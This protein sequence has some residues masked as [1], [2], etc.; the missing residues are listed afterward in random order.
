LIFWFF[1]EL[2]VWLDDVFWM[3]IQSRSRLGRK[4]ISVVWSNR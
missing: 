1:W 3:S 2:F 4:G